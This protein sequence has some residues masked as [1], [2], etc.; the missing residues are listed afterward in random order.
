MS[1]T[2]ERLKQPSDFKTK[3]Q[4]LESKVKILKQANIAKTN[5]IFLILLRYLQIQVINY[6]S[7]FIKILYKTIRVL[8]RVIQTLP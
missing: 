3:A 4:S 5:L 2:R 7:S 8:N 6:D 1:K